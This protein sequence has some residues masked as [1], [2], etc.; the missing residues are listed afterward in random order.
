MET[1]DDNSPF[2]LIIHIENFRMPEMITSS[3]ADEIEEDDLSTLPAPSEKVVGD[4][5]IM[6]EYMMN[7]DGKKIK[8][9]RTFKVV[10][11]MVPKS[12]AHRKRWEKFG[13]SRNDRLGPNPSTTVV[14][15]EIFMQVRQKYMVSMI[16]Q[17][18]FKMVSCFGSGTAGIM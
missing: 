13:M 6:T 4:T 14:T 15:D 3:W 18:D 9:V 2:C 1:I 17:I 10:K 8:I 7:D 11:K 5:K 12:I 16:Q